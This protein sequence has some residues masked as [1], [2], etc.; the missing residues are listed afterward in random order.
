MTKVVAKEST[1]IEEL[2][3]KLL[4]TLD[5]GAFFG[6][7]TKFFSKII[8]AD[9]T[10]INLVH[11]DS[12]IRL[13]AKNG[14]AIKRGERKIKGLGAA[15]HVVKTKRAYFS[16]SVQRDPI[17][18]SSDNGEFVAELCVPVS[19]DGVIIGTIH[20][21]RKSD[22]NQFGR[23]CI[24]EVV[25][26]LNELQAPL[27]NMK[28]Y[29]S[30]KFLNESLQKQIKEKEV[31]LEKNKNGIQ[32]VDTF[33]VEEKEIIGKSEAMTNLLDLADRA[34][35]ASANILIEGESGTG[36]EM[37]ARRLH[38]RSSRADKAFVTVDCSMGSEDDLEKELFGREELD[39][40]NNIR[41]HKGCVEAANGG[42]IFV[43]NIDKLP[44]R[45][46]SKLISFINDRIFFRAG[47]QNPLRSNVRVVVASTKDLKELVSEGTFRE[48]LYFNLSTISLRVPSLKERQEDIE[49]LASHF[50]NLGKSV[51]DQKSMSPGV[52]NL[53]NDYS[54]PGN[55]RELQ[56]IM[57][58]AYILSASSIIEKDHLADSIQADRVEEKEEV[59][60]ERGYREMT[61]DELEREHICRTLEH[62][63][64]NKTKTAKVLG[65][66]VKTLYNKLHSYGMIASKEA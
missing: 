47:T 43:N 42:T 39:A 12:S 31:E 36:K 53:L 14:R 50:L 17:F 62:L 49:V 6:D 3:S 52:V 40:S 29:L 25:E 65:I 13:I 10:I 56:S 9:E 32:L 23:D 8:S 4:S 19:V 51:E 45:L 63:S 5:E 54:W 18:A 66:T 27:A 60:E 15:G 38:C 20:F 44:V 41:V 34:A 11:E 48:D 57:E 58:R 22:E 64:G 28:M 55:V 24:N 26:T 61:L 30:A 59:V 46:Q 1:K 16:N 7:L 21:R 35:Q 2:S 33:R 37:I